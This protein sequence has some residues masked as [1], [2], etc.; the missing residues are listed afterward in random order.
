[1]YNTLDKYKCMVKSVR[2]INMTYGKKKKGKTL[3]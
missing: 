3:S 2:Q 1:M